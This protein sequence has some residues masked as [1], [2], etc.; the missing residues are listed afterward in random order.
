MDFVHF[1][2]GV[3]FEVEVLLDVYWFVVDIFGDLAIY[4]FFYKEL[5]KIH[6]VDRNVLNLTQKVEL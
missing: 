4:G 2:R 5:Y 1:L 6:F 3:A